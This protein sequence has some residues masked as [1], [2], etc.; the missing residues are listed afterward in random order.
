MSYYYFLSALP[1]LF[2]EKRECN[3]EAG[4]FVMAGTIFLFWIRNINPRDGLLGLFSGIV[5]V[6]L[7]LFVFRDDIGVHGGPRRVSLNQAGWGRKS[8]EGGGC[9]MS[10]L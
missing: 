4:R 3:R 1:G 7:C 6:F 8:I 10:C 9:P 2:L 5:F